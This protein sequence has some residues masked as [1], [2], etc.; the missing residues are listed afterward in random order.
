ML[1]AGLILF[2]AVLQGVTELF[3]VSS[4]GHAVVVPPLLHLAFHQSAP[5]FVPVLALLH[6]GTAA[7]LLI[8]FRREWWSIAPGFVRA[9]W[10]GQVRDPD[11][12][13]ALMLVVGTLPAGIV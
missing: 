7:A 6:L 12:R 1:T 5:A 2:L 13:L 3:P 10:R 8:L 11:E 4:L 9:V